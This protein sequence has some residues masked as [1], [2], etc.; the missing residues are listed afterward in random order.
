VPDQPMGIAWSRDGAAF[1]SRIRQ[2][3]VV[4]D[5]GGQI[6]REIDHYGGVWN[7][8]PVFTDDKSIVA[9][10]GHAKSGDIAFSV[11]DT[12]T[13]EVLHEEKIQ[14]SEIAAKGGD[15]LIT[16]PWF[17]AVSTDQSR[18]A[19]ALGGSRRHHSVRVYSTKDW[20]R[21]LDLD[22]DT[23]LAPNSSTDSIVLSGDGA[24]L[25]VQ[26][27]KNIVIVDV[28]TG[29]VVQKIVPWPAPGLR[30]TLSPDGTILAATA[31]AF[32]QGQKPDP[33]QL[34]RVSDGKLFGSYSRVA[35][36][37]YELAWD[38]KGRVVAFLGDSSNL[39]LWNPFAAAVSEKTITFRPNVTDITFAPDGRRLAIA[40][41]YYIDILRI[42]E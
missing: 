13:G 30:S 10:G 17:F 26:D 14:P 4:F 38:P 33:I 41:D 24:L 42:G 2:K 23:I 15:P 16:S 25:A 8:K 39:H 19:V 3:L 5:A 6:T 18:L 27:F 28:A 35:S 9:A 34:F 11:Y 21:L 1:V 20:S 36:N 22:L 12:A 7:P 31:S 40:N 29:N 37:V 32:L